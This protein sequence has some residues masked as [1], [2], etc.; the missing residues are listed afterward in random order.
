MAA[1][2]E[3]ADH[4]SHEHARALEEYHRLETLFRDVAWYN[5]ETVA[6]NWRTPWP[7]TIVDSELLL[8]GA[9]YVIE[10]RRGG[11]TRESARFP[12]YYSGPVSDAPPLPPEIVLHELKAAYDLVVALRD[13]CSAPYDWAP[14][15]RLYEEMVRTS[16]GV[17]A[18]SSDV[19][20]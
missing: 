9:R 7:V 16:E 20:V 10:E 8:R 4:F 2:D 3:F 18:F 6:R 14:G 13:A 12:V 1:M 11:R 19:M 17:R 15:G 5:F